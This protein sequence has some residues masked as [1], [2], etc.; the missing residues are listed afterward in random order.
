[1]CQITA[2]AATML[3]LPEPFAAFRATF[4]CFSFNAPSTA[5]CQG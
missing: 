1:M 2:L 4:E 3:V 5:S